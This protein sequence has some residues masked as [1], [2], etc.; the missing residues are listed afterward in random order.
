M[1]VLDGLSVVFAVTPEERARGMSGVDDA[2][3][4]AMLF[5][6]AP[7]D[8]FWMRGCTVPLDIVAADAEGAVIDFAT[9]RPPAGGEEPERFECPPGTVGVVEVEGGLCAAHGVRAGDVL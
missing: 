3:G 5:S 8:V 1:S 9:L 6:A 2:S 4:L 7:G